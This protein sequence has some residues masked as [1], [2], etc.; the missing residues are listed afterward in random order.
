MYGV[1]SLASYRDIAYQPGVASAL[2]NVGNAYVRTMQMKTST[3]SMLNRSD[4]V[5]A[6][7]KNAIE[8]LVPALQMLLEM[9]IADGPKQCL[10]GLRECCKVLGRERF[11]SECVRAGMSKKQAE[12]LAEE[13]SEAT[14]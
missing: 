13:R 4:Q 3:S 1:E 2:G 12:E 7:A 5:D 6:L 8:Y 14:E 11:V 10:W 9:G